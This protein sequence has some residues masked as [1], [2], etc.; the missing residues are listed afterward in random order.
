ML[1]LKKKKKVKTKAG[2]DYS[3][4]YRHCKKR[5]LIRKFLNVIS[6]FKKME[7]GEGGLIFCDDIYHK[8]N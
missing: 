6:F 1:E 3:S 5:N 8:K 4:Y 2:N 7:K